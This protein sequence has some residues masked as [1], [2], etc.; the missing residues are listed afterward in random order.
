MA[1]TSAKS[2]PS[3][4]VGTKKSSSVKTKSTAVTAYRSA[5]SGSFDQHKGVDQTSASTA[6]S[7]EQISQTR[8]N[9]LSRVFG[10]W[11]GDET[12]EEI[13]EALKEMS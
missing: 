8:P 5:H 2:G 11:P 12:E 13:Q 6:K 3:K 7:A 1:K 9:N 4:K 10:R